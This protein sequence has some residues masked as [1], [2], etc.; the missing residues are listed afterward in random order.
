MW[1][2]SRPQHSIF[3]VLDWLGCLK[4]WL[5]FFVNIKHS[6]L[7]R[8]GLKCLHGGEVWSLC[9]SNAW[10]L[11]PMWLP[12]VSTCFVQ[13]VLIMA[14]IRGGWGQILRWI[15]VFLDLTFF[16]FWTCWLVRRWKTMLGLPWIKED[17]HA[18][19]WMCK[20]SSASAPIC[21]TGGLKFYFYQKCLF[22]STRSESESSLLLSHTV[23]CRFAQNIF[24]VKVQILCDFFHRKV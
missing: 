21:S 15:S 2:A 6:K 1:H 12:V 24:P 11:D 3:V 4:K 5:S 17:N 19:Y 22:L 14:F 16:S 18:R 9:W 7:Y 20:E 23:K 13:P 8:T 10:F